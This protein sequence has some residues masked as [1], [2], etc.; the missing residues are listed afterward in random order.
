MTVKAIFGNQPL[1]KQVEEKVSTPKQT[2]PSVLFNE[3]SKI[4]KVEKVTDPNCV[5][6]PLFND[7]YKR[8]RPNLLVQELKAKYNDISNEV[9]DKAYQIILTTNCDNVNQKDII[10]WGFDAQQHYAVLI[11]MIAN[12]SN[13][14]LLE[15]TKKLINEIG[16]LIEND[17]NNSGIIKKLFRKTD[18]EAIYKKIA[19]KTELVKR[20]VLML[21]NLLDIV[22][23]C[24]QDTNKLQ[25]AINI[26][27]IAGNYLV[28]KV[29]Q[30]YKDAF[31][32]RLVSLESLNIQFKLTIKQL[33]ILND[34][35]VKVISI[36]QDTLTVEVPVWYNNKAF[37]K[38]SDEQKQQII[39]KIKL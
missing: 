37:E 15:A 34:T 1:K 31:Q 4:T 33:E 30:Q 18:S 21:H 27:L 29:P 35:I 22:A 5:P 25:D 32:T 12:I 2:T 3:S 28:D 36:I 6:F 10:N 9:I 17:T 26:D 14:S 8:T 20:N 13:S 16:E 19:I 24:K 39:T 23:S 7:A 11:E 38:I